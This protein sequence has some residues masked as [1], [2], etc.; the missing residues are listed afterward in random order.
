[1]M[2][3]ASELGYIPSTLTLVRVFTSMPPQM[4]KK[5]SGSIMYR[6]ASERFLAH[7]RKNTDPNAFTL[8]GLIEAKKMNA[9]GKAMAMFARAAKAWKKANKKDTTSLGEETESEP[10]GEDTQPAEPAEPAARTLPQDETRVK[11]SIKAPDVA[12]SQDF[13]LPPPREPRWEWEVSNVLGQAKIYLKDP[14]LAPKAEQI[15]RVAAVELDNPFAFLML[16]KLMDGPRNSAERRTYLIKAA[17]S[18]EA[19]ACFELGALEK[20]AA[21]EATSA[22]QRAQHELLSVE[23]FRLGNA[24]DLSPELKALDIDDLEASS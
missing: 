15:F 24:E 16:A 19:E 5:A 12:A 21:A 14:K 10:S 17:I 7:L 9:D 2:R 22:K 8:Q 4:F 20:L 11:T 23:W 13:T 1:M 6:E 18:G 3:S